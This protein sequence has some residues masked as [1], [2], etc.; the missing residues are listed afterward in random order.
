MPSV[1]NN[2]IVVTADELVPAYFNSLDTLKQTI[3]RYQ[4]KDYGIKK[5]Q[6]GGNNRQMLVAFDSLPKEMQ[7][8]IG[9]PRKI[10]NPLELFYKVD[11]DAVRFFTNYKFE[12]ET[13]LS[14]NH[15]DEYITNASV[16]KAAI[17]LKEAR[18]YERRSKKGSLVGIMT[19]ICNDVIAFNK[20]LQVKHNSKHTLPSSEKRFKE[21]FKEF[22]TGFNY[23]CLISGRLRNENRKVVTDY[24]LQLLNDLFADKAQ[25]PTR[26]EV[27]RLYGSFLSGYVEVINTETGELYNHT[28]FKPISENTIINYL[29]RWADKIGTHRLRSGDRQK[30]MGSF[31]PY[32]SMDKPNYAGSIISV[33]DRQPPFK[34]DSS[35]NRVWFY[36]GI[37]LGS[38]A[39]V[40]WVHGKSKEG[41]IT[42]F[43]RQLVRNYAAWGM[44][45]P[46]EIE[47]ESNLNASFK[48]TFLQPGRMFEHV[49]IEANNARGKRI[50]RYFGSLRYGSEKQREGWLA[51]PHARS[52]AN[53]SGG[54]IVP[55]VPY[56]TI[57]D[58]CLRDI[59]DWNNTPHSVHTDKTRW[60]VFCEMQNPNLQP[61][62]W[63]AI[64]P[65]LGYITQTTCQLNG[66]IHLNNSE[67]L[68]G[69]DGEV[70]LGD[71]LINMMSQV[72]GKAIDVYW[73]DGNNGEVIKAII[74]LKNET[75]P[76]CEAVIK[77][78]YNRATIER[79]EKDNRAYEIMSAYTN[80]I[81]AYAARKAQQVGKVLVI[82]NSDKT[83]NRGFVIP[84]VKRFHGEQSGDEPEIINTDEPETELVPVISGRSLK[85]RF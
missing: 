37:D 75:T 50:E 21:T 48:N 36:N 38:E 59:E 49:R 68:L 74:F 4:T 60:E 64:L 5:V 3:S 6:R 10:S 83:L 45:V 81:D 78:R 27:S 29:G 19:T 1:W 73:L 77:P 13:R 33:D 44:Q 22:A 26:T 70:L 58:G 62:N 56:N 18:E 47:C 15:Q 8:A 14:L 71:R 53:Q 55:I 7:E 67:F 41:I 20:V 46:A 54:G 23:G 28:D 61:T 2:I 11:P 40:C 69:L 85:D 72:A 82:D 84:G 9:D 35:N 16:L 80:T 57:V 51:R 66:I 79:T 12:D 63:S 65:H 39:W 76:I 30:Y 31:K 34:Y 52:E 17:F 42:D 43:Y 32:H 25:K 24:M